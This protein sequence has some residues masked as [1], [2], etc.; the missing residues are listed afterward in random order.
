MTD[1]C[2]FFN[3]KKTVK[4]KEKEKNKGK[5][6]IGPVFACNESSGVICKIT[7]AQVFMLTYS[8]ITNIQS[9]P[10]SWTNTISLM[11]QCHLFFSLHISATFTIL[12]LLSKSANCCFS[13]VFC[14]G[15]SISDTGNYLKSIGDGYDPVRNLPYGETYFGHPTGRFSDGRIILDFIG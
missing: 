4:G 1:L 13:R 9:I 10:Q 5:I 8:Q 15:D 3:H 6:N 7:L 12:L 14:F 11:A 2:A